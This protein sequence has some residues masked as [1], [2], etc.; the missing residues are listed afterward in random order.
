MSYDVLVVGAGFAGLSAAALLG[1]A[2]I[3][4]AVAEQDRQVGGR[5]KV[6]ETKGF[7]FEY[8]VHSYRYG[9]RGAAAGVLDELASQVEWIHE[10]VTSYVIQGKELLALPGGAKKDMDQAPPLYNQEEVRRIREIVGR[11]ASSSPDEWYG[12]SFSDFLGNEAGDKKM[13]LFFR[14]LSFGLMEPD[15]EK[16]SAGELIAHLKKALAAGV[17]SAEPKGGTRQ[18]LNRLVNCIEES[19]GR[20]LLRT[21]VQ[22]LRVNRKKVWEAI[23][24]KGNIHADTV[25]YAAPLQGL[26]SVIDKKHFKARFI[27]QCERLKPTAGVAIDY[28]LNRRISDVKGW[29]MDVEEGILARFPS[30]LDPGLAP[31]GKQISSWFLLLEPDETRDRNLVR[32]R[33]RQLKGAIKNLFPDFFE[34][35]EFERIMALPIVD[36]ADPST[37]QCRP[38]RPDLSCQDIKNLFFIGDSTAGEGVSGDI[39]FNSA[40]EVV[41]RVKEFLGRA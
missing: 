38:K 24:S 31:A 14:I 40:R 26:F 25:I 8:G 36:G 27:R 21:K 1:K 37:Q 18:I 22:E 11:L 34:A 10:Q 15:P 19:G 23:T 12:K 17:Q 35:V 28:G 30:N 6:I 32:S 4:V 5:A 41:P 16:L 33:I 7:L 9:A 13:G 3:H 2:G 29:L 39:A 20:I